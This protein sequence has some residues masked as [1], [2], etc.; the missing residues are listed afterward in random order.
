MEWL[1]SDAHPYAWTSAEKDATPCATV[2]LP[3][4]RSAPVLTVFQ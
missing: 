3:L 1:P 4:L 2:L